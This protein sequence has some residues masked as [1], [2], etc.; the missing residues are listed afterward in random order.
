MR[1]KLRNHGPSARSNGSYGTSKMI[2]KTAIYGTSRLYRQHRGQG[3]SSHQLNKI[4]EEQCRN[5]HTT[6]VEQSRWEAPTPDGVP[7]PSPSFPAV[8][9]PARRT[10]SALRRA[11]RSRRRN[12]HRESGD[13]ASPSRWVS[14][15]RTRCGDGYRRCTQSDRGSTNRRSAAKSPQLGQSSV[16]RRE[17]RR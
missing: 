14:T 2:G 17:S 15:S 13:P 8:P 10:T 1:R 12:Q 7:V 16:R 9:E 11:Q 6:T 3:A 4:E 5:S